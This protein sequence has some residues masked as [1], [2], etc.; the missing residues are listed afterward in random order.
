MKKGTSLIISSIISG[1]II[2]QSALIAPAI[3]ELLSVNEASVFL[4]YIWPKFFVAIGALAFVSCMSLFPHRKVGLPSYVA[5]ITLALMIGCFVLTPVINNAKDASN[6]GLW[7]A[8][9]VTTVLMTLGVL[10]LNVW[11]LVHLSR[12]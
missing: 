12:K 3:N 9:H 11:N 4:R 5:V 7:S 6:E 10:I 1:I 2:F 8:L